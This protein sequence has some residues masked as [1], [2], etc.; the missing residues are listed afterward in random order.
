[1]GVSHPAEFVLVF[2]GSLVLIVLLSS[3]WTEVGLEVLGREVIQAG[4]K[5]SKGLHDQRTGFGSKH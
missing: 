5:Y 2:V 1:M 3:Q 4:H